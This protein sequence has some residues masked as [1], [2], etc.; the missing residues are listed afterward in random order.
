MYLVTEIQ[1]CSIVLDLVKIGILRTS[2]QR[3]CLDIGNVVAFIVYPC[4]CVLADTSGKSTYLN[5]HHQ[6]SKWDLPVS[7]S[8]MACLATA[9]NKTFTVRYSRTTLLSVH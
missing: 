5:Q 2:C 9:V 3:L 7:V 8:S 6:N 4:T 1:S